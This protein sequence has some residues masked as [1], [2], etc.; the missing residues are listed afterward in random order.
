MRILASSVI[1]LALS[2]CNPEPEGEP[3]LRTEIGSG[4]A[5]DTSKAPKRASA[6]RSITFETIP[7][8][9]CIADP[10]KHRITTALGPDG[11]APYRSL[12]NLAAG[13]APD[14][15]LVAFAV[16]GGMF[17]EEGKPIGYY[18]EGKDR[19]KE[20]NR[21]DGIGNFHLKP[22]GVF[23]GTGSA[24]SVR[25]TDDFYSN[26]GD[27]PEF[28]TQ[29]GPMLV[30]GGKLHP[31]IAEDGPS[32]AIRNGV[33][34]DNEGLAHFVISDKPLSFGVLARFFRD[35]LKTP[36][37]LFLDGN[38][39]ALWDPAND[40]LDLGAALGPLIVVEAKE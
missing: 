29:S 24:W 16:N 22:N 28:G 36:N 31:E 15:P 21:A 38:V 8:T 20:L 14:A 18:V 23:Y 27:R 7:L 1:I 10:A 11:D 13:R 25:A 33:G 30:I 39:S 35:E 40:R 9:H 34:V 2:A 19:Q 26:V 37:A 3:V 12:A 32:K 6:C 4:V 17:G 5:Q